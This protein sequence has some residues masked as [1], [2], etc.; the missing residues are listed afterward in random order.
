MRE[1]AKATVQLRPDRIAL[2]SFALVPW[3]KPAQRLFKDEDLP[4]AAEK[5]ELYEVVSE[6][7]PLPVSGR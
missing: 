3:I 6:S 1:T 5:R 2:Y 4:K 7:D